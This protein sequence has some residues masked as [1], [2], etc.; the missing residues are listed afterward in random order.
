MA[1][2]SSRS[3]SGEVKGK[4]LKE[5]PALDA[6]RGGPA[7]ATA[8]VA[9]RARAA[10]STGT[11]CAREK[12]ATPN[13]SPSRRS[14]SAQGTSSGRSTRSRPASTWTCPQV[15][16]EPAR[17]DGQLLHEEGTVAALERDLVIAED[18]VHL[19]PND[20]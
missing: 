20:R 10:K 18:D 8:A 2:P 9:S 11:S 1:A 6:E 5:P 13:R 12:F 15:G 3:I 16:Q 7:A 19:R 4:A 17:V 14:A